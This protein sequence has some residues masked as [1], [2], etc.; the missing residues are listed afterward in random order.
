VKVA[1]YAIAKDE[2]R[3]IERFCRAA[4]AADLILIAD[5]GSTD[6]TPELGEKNGADVCHIQVRP[7]RYDTARNLALGLVPDDM[8]LC[9][10]MDL[11]EYL[12]EGWREELE[13]VWTPDVV[14]VT[15]PFKVGN[16]IW[17]NNKIHS[18]F[19]FGW[20]HPV[21]ECLTKD[22]RHPG[23]V[24][25][26]DRQ[27]I[28][29][30]PVLDQPADKHLQMLQWAFEQYADSGRM[31]FYFARDLINS[32]R[33]AEAVP[34]LHRYLTQD[35]R[36]KSPEKAWCMKMLGKH[37]Q[38]QKNASEA[39]LWLSRAIE[40]APDDQDCWLALGHGYYAQGRWAEAYGVFR[41]AVGRKRDGFL[42]DPTASEASAWDWASL[43][44]SRAGLK[45][46]AVACAERA[47]QL[48]PDDRIQ[49][50]LRA[51]QDELAAVEISRR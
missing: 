1:V 37:H 33:L 32:G 41:A 46:E 40:E 35:S 28:L 44:A 43:A 50:N 14:Q 51:F 26:V 49:A 42:G 21:H 7:W 15:Y 3:H 19:G 25:H 12:C 22:L 47:L 13:R 17:T 18:R 48:A 39:L 6:K 23:R 2:E 16:S 11:D 8:D 20:D 31:A 4:A 30:D 38:D 5:T 24:V 27:L 29:H 45:S 10:A 34:A 9:I 36:P